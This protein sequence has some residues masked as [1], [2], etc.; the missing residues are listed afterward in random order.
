MTWFLSQGLTELA[1]RFPEDF[2]SLMEAFEGGTG[3]KEKPAVRH[4]A[5]RQP[6][7]LPAK[8]KHMPMTRNIKPSEIRNLANIIAEEEERQ[9]KENFK[10]GM[11]KKNQFKDLGVCQKPSS[12]PHGQVI[13]C[14]HQRIGMILHLP[15]HQRRL[16]IS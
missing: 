8:Q 6:N 3:E 13:E 4:L 2:S 9:K 7:V 11:L 5:P 16:Y 1:E 10:K 14:L 15:I 12:P